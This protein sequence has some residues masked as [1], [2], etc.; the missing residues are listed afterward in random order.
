MRT[1]AWW[2]AVVASVVAGC[3]SERADR[4]TPATGLTPAAP[5]IVRIETLDPVKAAFNAHAGEPRIVLLVSPTCSEC[6]LGAEAVRASVV[7]RFAASGVHA[8]V[9]WEA[10]LDTDDVA[11]AQEASRI[12]AG[13]SATQFDDPERLSGW[14]FERDRFAHKW[15]EVEAA[16]PE[17]HWLRAMVDRKPEPSAE[18]DLYMLYRPGVRWE[19]SAPP[20]DAFIRHIGRDEQGRSRF[21]R[22]TFA[23]PPTVGDL[24]DAMERMGRDLLAA[25][26]A[27]HTTGTARIELLGFPDCP[28]TP[29]LRGHLRAAL[30]A[31]GGGL[32]FDDVNQEALAPDDLRRGWPTPTVLVDGADL[33]DLPAPVAPRMSCRVYAGGIPDADT[34]AARLRARGLP[35]EQ[36]GP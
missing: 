29:A 19:A 12:F 35:S 7:D 5:P 31:L 27:A 15:D 18:W 10:M 22:D 21:W 33:F 4:G 13:C 3:A 30:A 28:G 25:P 16:L 2:L 32:A 20:P 6:L 26:R 9:V 8:I 17:D 1:R 36:A 34:L 24:R 23:A 11:A 14:A